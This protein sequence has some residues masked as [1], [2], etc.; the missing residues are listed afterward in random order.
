MKT[1]KI[2]LILMLL[3]VLNSC[4]KKMPAVESFAFDT[5]DP[6]AIGTTTTYVIEVANEGRVPVTN[7]VVENTF[8]DKMELIKADG[9]TEYSVE[10]N[11]V[12]FRPVAKLDPEQGASYKITCKALAE[13]DADNV[14]ILKYDQWPDQ[15]KEEESTKIYK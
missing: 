15:I 11:K 12:I 8:S 7:I 9:P 5:E 3:L 4:G 6:I 10:G 14:T 1:L 13:G 2:C